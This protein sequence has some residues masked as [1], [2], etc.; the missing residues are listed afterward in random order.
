MINSSNG[1]LNPTFRTPIIHI[2]NIAFHTAPLIALTVRHDIH[3][4]LEQAP[5]LGQ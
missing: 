1:I 4:Y 2:Q 3:S 5:V